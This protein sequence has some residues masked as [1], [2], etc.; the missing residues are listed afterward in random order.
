MHDDLKERVKGLE[1]RYRHLMEHEEHVNQTIDRN[2][3]SQCASIK[4]IVAE[5]AELRKVVE[6]LANRFDRPQENE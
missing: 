3:H 1:D 5:Q 4:A 6:D 2:T